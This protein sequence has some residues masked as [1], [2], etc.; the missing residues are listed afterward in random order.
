[1]DVQI[2][3]SAEDALRQ[4]D[5]KGWDLII[6]DHLLPGMTGL[7]LIH[8]RIERLPATKWIVITAFGSAE[9]EKELKRLKIYRYMTKPFPLEDLRQVVLEALDPH[10]PGDGP[11][12]FFV[13]KGLP[14]Q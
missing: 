5:R 8:A 4:V 11:Q 10:A 14:P 3:S 12:T 2:V 6:T 7:D 1:V 13:V 9:L